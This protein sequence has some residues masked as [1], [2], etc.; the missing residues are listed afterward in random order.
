VD[1]VTLHQY[2][3]KVKKMKCSIKSC[4][5]DALR[6]IDDKTFPEQFGYCLHHWRDIAG[7]FKFFKLIKL[8]PCPVC[9]KIIGPETKRVEGYL[10]LIRGWTNLQE[11][12][13]DEHRTEQKGDDKSEAKSI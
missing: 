4:P 11:H 8:Y 5:D 2:V 9:G 1:T 7:N 3:L 13:K 10:K 6:I 12:I